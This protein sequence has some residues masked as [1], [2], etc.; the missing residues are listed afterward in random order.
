[1]KPLQS[2]SVLVYYTTARTPGAARTGIV[3]IY[4]GS[5]YWV[6]GTGKV[7]LSPRTS[8]SLMRE[9]E[10]GTGNGRIKVIE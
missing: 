3:S 7:Y 4:L 2:G 10:L 9:V 6:L 1:M 5:G 8:E